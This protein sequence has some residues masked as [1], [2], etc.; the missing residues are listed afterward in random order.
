[1]VD[2]ADLGTGYAAGPGYIG[3]SCCW[4]AAL[5]RFSMHLLLPVPGGGCL[6]APP[7]RAA[8]DVSSSKA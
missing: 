6:S 8:A 7:P 3:Y 2:H 1:M 4:V 5:V